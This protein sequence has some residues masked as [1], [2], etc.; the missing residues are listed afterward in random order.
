VLLSW[1]EKFNYYLSD[2][3]CMLFCIALAKFWCSSCVWHIEVWNWRLQ[4]PQ[5]L[6][7]MAHYA[8]ANEHVG[9]IITTLTVS[10]YGMRTA[11][12]CVVLAGG[13]LN[14]RQCPPKSTRTGLQCQRR[15][16]T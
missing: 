2:A 9:R 16:L 15:V 10:Y 1:I 8:F 12:M 7:R 3:I 11:N 14:C 4:Q 6:S 13:K 5:T